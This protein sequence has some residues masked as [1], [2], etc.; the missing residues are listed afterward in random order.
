MQNTNY[1]YPNV[2]RKRAKNEPLRGGLRERW[3]A[4]KEFSC[5]YMEVPGNFLKKNES[6]TSLKDGAILTEEAIEE[7]YQKDTIFPS[8]LR[9]ILHTDPELESNH[10]L[11]WDK[12]TWRREFAEMIINIS[13]YF[14]VEP[15]II[16]IHPSAGIKNPFASIV[17]GIIAILDAFQQTSK[18]KP[19]ILLENRTY[20]QISNGREIRDFWG[21]LV[22]NNKELIGTTGIVLDF[23]TLF[24]Q[25]KADLRKKHG[26]VS[27]EAIVDSFKQDLM[28][29]PSE[30]LKAYHIHGFGDLPHQI[31]K[32]NDEI[33]WK[34]VFEKIKDNKSTIIINPEVLNNNFVGPTIDFCNKMLGDKTS[35]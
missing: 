21:F 18:N 14:E 5:K 17:E 3:D 20:K 4:A 12:V 33:P 31:P 26:E 27:S 23:K 11:D 22:D 2:S 16:E 28:K 19:V 24:T 8:E 9:Y 29:I 7:L 34:N 30:A 15:S 35:E 10:K 1:V 13:N 25:N 32:E 6:V